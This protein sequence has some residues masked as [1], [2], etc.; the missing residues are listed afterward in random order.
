VVQHHGGV[1]VVVEAEGGAKNDQ[2]RRGLLVTARKRVGGGV[3][4]ARAVFDR[5][6]K[7]E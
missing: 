3:E 1:N 4:A 2:H 5:E 6:V 7:P